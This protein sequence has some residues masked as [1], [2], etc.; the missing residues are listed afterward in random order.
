VG[1]PTR[2]PAAGGELVSK[3]TNSTERRSL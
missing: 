1:S 3:D 2:G